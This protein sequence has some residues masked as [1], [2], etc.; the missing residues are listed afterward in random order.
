MS[1]RHIAAVLGE[2]LATVTADLE[3]SRERLAG[4]TV[5]S[6]ADGVFLIDRPQDLLGRYMRR[7]DLVGFVADLS[8]AT[9]R[10]AVRQADIGLIRERNLG[11]RVHLFDQF[12]EPVAARIM[13]EVPNAT[14]R[15]PSAVLGTLG[16]GA[17]PVD[18]QDEKGISALQDIFDI[19][20]ELEQGAERLG[21]RARVRFDHGSEPL[22]WQGY[23]RLRQLFL[24][25]FNV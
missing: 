18:P 20:L 15:L 13:R 16:G 4:L 5:R 25:Q 21:G 7:G 23:R 1:W 22:A 2:Q 6:A 17:I 12:G 24:R 10:V 14:D 3:L 8:Q 11:V 19:E 9:V